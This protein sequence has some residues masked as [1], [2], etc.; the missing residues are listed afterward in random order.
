MNAVAERRWSPCLIYL[1]LWSHWDGL[2]SPSPIR[3]DDRLFAVSKCFQLFE[4]SVIALCRA[5]RKVNTGICEFLHYG[6]GRAGVEDSDS[7]AEK[8]LA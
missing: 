8:I 5:L 4:K 3:F 1:H 7:E 6:G 2:N